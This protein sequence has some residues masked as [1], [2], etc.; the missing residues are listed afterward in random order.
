MDALTPSFILASLALL[1]WL[2]LA[3][4][5]GAFWRI[6]L[7]PHAPE[8]DN[9]PSVDIIVPAR[10]EADM[11]P[12]SL[13]SL[14]VQDY[15]G[16]WRVLLVDDHSAD[17]TY[18]VA[19][20]V[21]R[22]TNKSDRLTVINAPDLPAGW[23]GKVATMR[24]GA[25]QSS[26]DYILFT[27]AD[28]AHNDQSLRRL[29][30]RTVYDNLDLNSLM[31]KLQCSTFAE[32][33]LIPA[34]VFF[35]A[36][37]YPFRLVNKPTSTVAAAA[38]GVMLVKRKALQNI[39]G[40]ERI[41][42]ALIDDCAL[43]RAIKDNGG[44]FGAQGRIRLSLTDNVH[45]LRPYPTIAHV[46]RMISRTAFTQLRYS[47][48]FL[49]GTVLGLVFLFFT[50][51]LVPLWGSPTE[52][53]VAYAALL[54]MAGIYAPIIYFYGFCVVWALTLPVAAL[55]YIHATLVSAWNYARGKGGQWKGRSQAP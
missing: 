52:S 29:M 45:S 15:P 11:L 43:A 41:K 20:R 10:N 27:D 49:L 32:K 26:S 7:D 1:G 12:Q 35:F 5:R 39:G 16:P 25:Q 42:S 37:L 44:N 33:L 3:L 47:Y 31:V 54:V 14:L 46:L 51:I 50:P 18:G 38:G 23:S 13:P 8:P 2:Y 36:M 28:I 6:L 21:A 40:L 48:L 4:M 19:H 17:S 34:F 24:A 9:W 30:A 53:L 22:E 55:L